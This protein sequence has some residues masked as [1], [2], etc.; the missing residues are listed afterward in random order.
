M[1]KDKFKTRKG[2]DW[3]NY[4]LS[5]AVLSLQVAESDYLGNSFKGL[6]YIF[7]KLNGDSEVSHS[8]QEELLERVAPTESSCNDSLS[9]DFSWLS[10]FVFFVTC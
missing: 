8:I 6:N 1:W 9:L 10:F 5:T 3:E 7:E 2:R 4:L